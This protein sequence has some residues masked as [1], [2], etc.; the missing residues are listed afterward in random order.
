M[1]TPSAPAP[2]L[3]RGPFMPP[4]DANRMHHE[5]DVAGARE[6]FLAHR[7]RNLEALLEQRYRWMNEWIE[8]GDTVVELGCGAGFS[9]LYVERGQLLLTD[10]VQ[11]DWVDRR[12]DAMAPDFEPGSVD[13]VICSHMIHHMARPVAF[14]RKIHPVLRSGGRILVQDLNTALLMRV[15]LRLMRH[16]GWS[17]EIDVFD[18]SQVTND[19]ED[20]WSANCAIPELL[21]ASNEAFERE[22]PGFRVV[23]NEL[24]ECL[25]FPLSGGVIAKTPVP[26]LPRWLLG[27][28]ARLD[29]ALVRTA[30]SLFAMG[31]SVVLAKV[32]AA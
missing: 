24:N 20:P 25:L 1:S 3:L 6:R 9:R 10:Y 15:L 26:E 22:I 12:V 29:A 28:V 19:P 7:F 14:F 23:R 5:G 27:W 17:Y 8:P 4:H 13:V 18:E 2:R 30:P 32:P 11:N 16:E 21:F 31:R